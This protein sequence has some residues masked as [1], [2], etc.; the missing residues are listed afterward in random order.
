[1]LQSCHEEPFVLD[2]IVAISALSTS[3]NSAGISAYHAEFAYKKYDHAIQTMRKSLSVPAANSRMALIACLLVCS[4]ESLCGHYLNTLQHAKSGNAIL[5]DWVKRHAES[6]VAGIVSPDSYVIEDALI[7]SFLHLD[8]QILSFFDSRPNK[9]HDV[10]KHDGEI[11]VEK[12]PKSFYALD[13]ARQFLTLVQTR[14]MVITPLV[15]FINYSPLTR[16]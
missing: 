1:M 11:S 9:V 5:K 14:T 16:C 8:H 12:M 6:A 3:R 15:S 2:S 10:G 7:Q 4:F 13:E